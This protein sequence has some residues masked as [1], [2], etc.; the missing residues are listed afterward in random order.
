M[1]PPPFVV[2]L[3]SLPLFRSRSRHPAAVEIESAIASK[4][5]VAFVIVC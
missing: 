4:L 3:Q 1:L 5:T 2:G